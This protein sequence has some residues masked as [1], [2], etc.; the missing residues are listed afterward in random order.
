[1]HYNIKEIADFRSL[2]TTRLY[3]LA[4]GF[5]NKKCFEISVNEL[6]EIFAVGDNYKRYADFK[7][8]TFDHGCKEINRIY[9]NTMNLRFKEVKEGR[10]VARIQFMFDSIPVKIPALL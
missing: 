7:K 2:Y 1:M 4:V 9:H 8:Y 3:E 5:K 10:K 6:R